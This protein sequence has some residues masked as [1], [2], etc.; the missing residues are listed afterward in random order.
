M[1]RRDRHILLALA[2]LS[3][4]FAIVQSATGISPDVLLAVPALMLLVPLLAGRYVGEAGLARLAGRRAAPRRRTPARLGAR[5]RA[6]RAL[7]RGGRLI[8]TALA[9][10]GPPAPLPA[11][12]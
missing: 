2:T 9:E 6:P 5:R 12:A 8:A 7:P 4:A 3:V 11:R 1:P 10:R